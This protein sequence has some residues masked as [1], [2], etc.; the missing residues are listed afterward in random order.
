MT[1]K[2]FEARKCQNLQWQYWRL[3]GVNH[4]NFHLCEPGLSLRKSRMKQCDRSNRQEKFPPTHFFLFLFRLSTWVKAIHTRG[5]SAS[6]SLLHPSKNTE[7]FPPDQPVFFRFIRFYN[8]YIGLLG[9]CF[10]CL[11]FWF[12]QQKR[13]FFCFSILL[14]W[15]FFGLS[16]L[17]S[18]S[19]WASL[20]V[21]HRLQSMRA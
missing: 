7:T 20:F 14:E 15:V 18:Y 17:S 12:L 8:W 2:I 21:A 13:F 1:H 6:L 11:F 5:Q 9:S 16:Q 19:E 3:K 4:V 10:L